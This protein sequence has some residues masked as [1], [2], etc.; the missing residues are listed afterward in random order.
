MSAASPTVNLTPGHCFPAGPD[1]SV[2][3]SMLPRTARETGS[4]PGCCGDID[5]RVMCA[6]YRSQLAPVLT[7]G[8][9]CDQHNLAEASGA[10]R[11]DDRRGV[12]TNHRQ[13]RLA[14]NQPLGRPRCCR[15]V[16]RG[17]DPRWRTLPAT[18]GCV[19]LHPVPMGQATQGQRHN[20][21]VVDRQRHAGGKVVTLSRCLKDRTAAR[22]RARYRCRSRAQWNE[23]P[24]GGRGF[25]RTEALAVS[26]QGHHSRHP[27]RTV[28]SSCR[29]SR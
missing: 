19:N 16:V 28:Q 3:R 23:G 24:T 11:P 9:C 21:I 2:S 27:K 29:P 1:Q 10:N 15:C 6:F 12:D 13:S 26:Q 20:G 5:Q 25:A 22:R 14:S 8:A 17:S 18:S 4:P 7:S